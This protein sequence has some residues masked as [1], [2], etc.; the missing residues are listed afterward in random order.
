MNFESSIIGI[1]VFLIIG[2]FHPVV[3]KTE[4]HV[5]VKARPIFLVAGIIVL[6]RLLL[7]PG[8]YFQKLWECLDY[9]VS[10]AFVNC[11]NRSNE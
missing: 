9:S 4:Y 8:L 7:F 6:R 11:T 2:V 3:I 10:G 1:A 5:G